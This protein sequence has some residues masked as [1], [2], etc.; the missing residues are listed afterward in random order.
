M[1]DEGMVDIARLEG[2]GSFGELALIDGKPRFATAKCCERTHFLVISV[3]DFRRAQ[4][5]IKA[6]ERDKKVDFLKNKV[7]LF[8]DSRPNMSTLRKLAYLFEIQKCTKDSIV[9]REG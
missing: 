6:N 1:Y 4:E 9:I 7:P 3:N 5:R 2:A 8:I